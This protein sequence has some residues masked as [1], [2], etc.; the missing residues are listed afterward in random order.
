[1]PGVESAAALMPPR[2]L[3]ACPHGFVARSGSGYEFSFNGAPLPEVAEAVGR[4]FSAAIE[5]PIPDSAKFTGRFTALGP[6]EALARIAD[7]TGLRI[8]QD[9][10]VWILG[11]DTSEGP[12][13]LGLADLAGAARQ[14]P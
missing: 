11:A 14:A 6:A 4:M 7:Q 9:G 12:R 2:V 1:M 8:R 3:V 5:L 13:E 10:P